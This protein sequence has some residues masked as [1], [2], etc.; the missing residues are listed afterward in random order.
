MQAVQI[1]YVYNGEYL[2]MQEGFN[3]DFAS[4]VG[5]VLRHVSIEKLIEE[6]LKSYD[7][8]GGVSEHKELWQ[9]EERLGH[10]LLIARPSFKNRLIFQSE[11]W[12]TGR[13]LT[14]VG[15]FDGN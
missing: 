9:A 7:F 6:G 14:E 11:I 12:P 2:A 8:L 4:G 1:G 3:P 15:L 10:D 5:N 13:Y